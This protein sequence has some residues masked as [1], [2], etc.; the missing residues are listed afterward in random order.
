MNQQYVVEINR[1]ERG[2]LKNF[3]LPHIEDEDGQFSHLRDQDDGGGRFGQ[4]FTEKSS[5]HWTKHVSGVCKH[6]TFSRKR[7]AW[8]CDLGHKVTKEFCA[9][10][11]DDIE[12]IRIKMPDGCVMYLHEEQR[13]V[14]H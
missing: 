7:C 3:T 14:R 9:D 6:S 4:N 11:V 8:V 13:V 10:W 1:S 2:L 5:D 12:N